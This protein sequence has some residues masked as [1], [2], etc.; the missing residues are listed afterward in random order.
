MRIHPLL[1]QGSTVLINGYFKPRYNKDEFEFKVMSVS[2][3]ET[4]KRNMTKQ[5]TIEA[6]PQSISAEVVS[7]MEKNMKSHPGKSTF[8]FTLT[9]PTNK[10]KISL[11]TMTNGFEMNEE[12]VEY[13][14]KK[15]E[16][17][18]QVQ[19]I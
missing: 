11:V 3:A 9:E 13:L 6:H 18:V 16:L 7:F 5:V 12:M 8:K 10:M 17:E 14:E 19:T 1:Q 15:P 2:L 4:M